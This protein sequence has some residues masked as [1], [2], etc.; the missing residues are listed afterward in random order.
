MSVATPAMAYSSYESQPSIRFIDYAGNPLKLGAVHWATSDGSKSLRSPIYASS[1]GEVSLSNLPIGLGT[2]WLTRAYLDS[3]ESVS[4]VWKNVNF[5]ANAP[6]ILATPKPPVRNSYRVEVRHSDGEPA[7]GVMVH[8]VGISNGAF[9]CEGDVVA[10][11][12]ADTTTGAERIYNCGSWLAAMSKPTDDFGLAEFVGYELRANPSATAE[13]TDS[14]VNHRSEPEAIT[15]DSATEI[16]LEPTLRVTAPTGTL[17]VK[18]NTLVTIPVTVGRT[19]KAGYSYG[20]Q[21]VTGIAVR[22]Q[23]STGTMAKT[24]GTKKARLV[25][26]TNS[27]GRATLQVC[28]KDTETIWVTTDGSTRSKKFTVQP[29]DSLPSAPRSVSVNVSPSGPIQITWVA[30]AIQGKSPIHSYR[31]TLVD[32]RT[33]KPRTIVVPS[34]G[35]LTKQISGLSHFT[36]YAIEVQAVSKVGLSQGSF[37]PTVVIPRR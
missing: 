5:S 12:S 6:L 28:A 34:T 24:C 32:I 4:A 37:W 11:F 7:T 19:S 33:H 10:E 13:Y 35:K 31:I 17:R 8:E 9:V 23:N 36:G 18:A 30:S 26:T 15:P 20:N 29:T 1:R 25:A 3:G 2:V 22:I 16:T 27:G 14:D 21:A